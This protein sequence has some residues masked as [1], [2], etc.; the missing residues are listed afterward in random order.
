MSAG[1]I[2]IVLLLPVLGC[3]VAATLHSVETASGSHRYDTKAAAHANLTASQARKVL[4][5]IPGLELKSGAIRVKSV[6]ANNSGGADVSADI[7]LVFKFETDRDGRWQVGEIRTGQDRWENIDQIARALNAPVRPPECIAPDPPFKGRLA[8]DPSIR[9]ARCLLGNLLGLE[10]PSDALRIQNVAPMPIPM[11]SQPSATV[12]AWV[13][14]EA[15]MTTGQ[16]GWQVSDLRTGN[17]D[18]VKLEPL[19]AALN[20][21][22]QQRARAELDMIAAAL[23]KFRGD[24]GFYVVSDKQATAIDY[25]SPRYLPRVIR[26]D[27]WHKPYQYLGERDRF[28]LSSSGP[29]G[30]PDTADDI[31]LKSR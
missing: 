5:R 25:L 12:V 1:S 19:M 18:W 10:V 20:Q 3:F 22:K 21:E 6:A 26:I 4:T 24:R 23:E 16:A 28:T 14:V 9:R 15:R 31:S 2:R 29:D 17:R 30:K 13:R 11:A 7:R 27:P 8:I